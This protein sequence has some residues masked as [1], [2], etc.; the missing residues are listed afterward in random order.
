M[1]TGGWI[2]LSFI[3]GM[4]A[5]VILGYIAQSWGEETGKKLRKIILEEEERRWREKYGDN[6]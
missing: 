1:T 6:D 4:L 3:F 5:G 2:L